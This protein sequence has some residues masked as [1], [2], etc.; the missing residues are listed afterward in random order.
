MCPD[1]GKSPGF[2]QMFGWSPVYN[3]A[4]VW[5]CD[6]IFSRNPVYNSALVWICN[7]IFGRNQVYSTAFMWIC[8][9]FFGRNPMYNSDFMWICD[10]FSEWGSTG[11]I[12][13]P[14]AE[15][16][17]CEVRVFNQWGDDTDAAGL[18]QGAGHGHRQGCALGKSQ[19]RK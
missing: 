6:V 19:A 18:G 14:Q 13:S 10:V 8:G 16:E 15:H 17:W 1:Q 2:F 5:I 9:V 4:L 11:H 7:V 3:V 12:Y